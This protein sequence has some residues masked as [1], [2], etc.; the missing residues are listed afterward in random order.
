[1]TFNSGK[2]KWYLEEKKTLHECHLRP[3]SKNGLRCDRQATN[4]LGYGA[5]MTLPVI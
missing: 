2:K 4:R 3:E 5:A 1:M